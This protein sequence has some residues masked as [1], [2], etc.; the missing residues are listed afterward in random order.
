MGLPRRVRKN[1]P[2]KDKQPRRGGDGAGTKRG[3]ACR[4]WT[5]T[6]QASCKK[7]YQILIQGHLTWLKDIRGSRKRLSQE[8]RESPVRDGGGKKT[9][10]RETRRITKFTSAHLGART[11]DTNVGKRGEGKQLKGRKRK[12]AP[13]GRNLWEGRKISIG[14]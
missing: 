10:P 14:V 7:N 3:V 11:G 5:F 1:T 9:V 6:R 4:E 2:K 12:T 8:D 13:R